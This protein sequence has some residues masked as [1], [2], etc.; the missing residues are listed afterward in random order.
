ML[1]ATKA[2][3]GAEGETTIGGVVAPTPPQSLLWEVGQ[4]VEAFWQ[5]DGN[6]Y[7]ATIQGIIG[8]TKVVVEWDDHDS[9][10]R[11]VSVDMLRELPSTS[12]PWSFARISQRAVVVNT[13]T[14]GRCLFANDDFTPGQVIFIEKPTLVALPSLA[15]EIW[16]RLKQIHEAE[17]FALG[18]TSFYYAA[19]VSILVLDSSAMDILMDKW[20]PSPDEDACDDIHR[21]IHILEKDISE[22]PVYK[23][24]SS[25]SA[26]S[27]VLAVE[28]RAVGART[29][30]GTSGVGG[31][32]MSTPAPSAPG[33]SLACRRL[34]HL[35]PHQVPGL[36]PVVWLVLS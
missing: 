9:S 16:Q 32:G 22:N 20:L 18:T 28:S 35:S 27:W 19:L 11:E 36:V 17:P 24:R 29:E 6:Y 31:A 26:L 14:K 25:S 23:V 30:F 7:A 4:R 1:H 15:P 33:R 34:T 13:A 2:S 21:I 5:G 12:S 8:E 3:P 10:H